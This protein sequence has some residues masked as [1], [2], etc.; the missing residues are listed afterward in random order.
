MKGFV[1]DRVDLCLGNLGI[2][3]LFNMK[4][5]SIGEWFYK[6]INNYQMND[7]FSGQG[8]EYTRGWNQ[9]AFTW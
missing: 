5:S 9:E 8:R 6:G 4:P 3:P 2:K 1:A 7:F